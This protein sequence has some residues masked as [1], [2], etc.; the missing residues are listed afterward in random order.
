[1]T[2]HVA[3]HEFF[4]GN[5]FEYFTPFSKF[6]IMAFIM[7]MVFF[8]SSSLYVQ[9]FVG[10]V[11]FYKINFRLMFGFFFISAFFRIANNNTYNLS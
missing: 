2:G 9:H 11:S 1:M 5:P 8:Y 4:H 3:K 6:P 10:V 7:G